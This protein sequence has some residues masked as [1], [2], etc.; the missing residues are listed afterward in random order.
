MGD[1]Q[2]LQAAAGD[3]PAA[4]IAI[5]EHHYWYCV[6][7]KNETIASVKV[8]ERHG[9]Q[10]MTDV[11]VDASY[12][13]KGLATRLVTAA[14]ARFGHEPLYLHVYGY[15]DRPLADEQ[16]VAFYARFGFVPIVDAPGMMCRPAEHR[17]QWKFSHA[18]RVLE[19]HPPLDE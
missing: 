3:A 10:W 8:Y 9:V 13:R 14:L 16:L 12:R 4:P 7:A 6:D 18:A 2:P 19:F 15:Y 17:D 5:N 11:W 1:E